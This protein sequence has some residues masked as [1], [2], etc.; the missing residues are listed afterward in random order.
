MKR[1]DKV[2]P[3]RKGRLTTI[4]ITRNMTLLIAFSVLVFVFTAVI[5]SS[6]GDIKR[7]V[8]GV[9]PGVTLEAR[10][11][12]GYLPLEVRR[13]IEAMADQERTA[14]KDAMIF[15]ETGE[16]IPESLGLDIDIDSTV[17]QVMKA[18]PGENIKLVRTVIAPAVTTLHFDPVYRVNTGM[19]FMA[20]AI[21]VAWGEEYLPRLLE[22]LREQNMKVTFFI[23]GTWAQ[24][25]PDVLKLL[26][27][28]GHELASHGYEH[29]H[30]E[31]LNESAI[32]QLISDNERL[33]LNLGVRP[34]KLFA[35]PY[36]ECNN[37]VIAAAASL[38][39][40]TVMWTIDTLDWNIKDSEKILGRVVPKI[41]SG[42]IILAHPTEIFL[43]VLPRIVDASRH[44]GY[45]FLTVS[46]L[47]KTE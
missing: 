38:G 2:A 32:K 30:I 13:I 14:P 26:D 47:I 15:K 43:E 39:Y 40:T 25:Y 46:E 21:N 3:K 44:S 7:M 34:S 4:I 20:F 16:L 29:V 27:E 28:E 45:Q 18:K 12:S 1:K 11:L 42:A 22:I 35:P 31:N 17:N 19:P 36:G 24:K 23:D 41:T 8:Y 37:T 5:I 10:V 6:F 9:K 33:L